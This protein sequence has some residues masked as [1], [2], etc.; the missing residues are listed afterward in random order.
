MLL[1]TLSRVEGNKTGMEM[2]QEE[3]ETSQH[4]VGKPVAQNPFWKL[5]RTRMRSIKILTTYRAVAFENLYRPTMSLY[6]AVH[7][8]ILL[9]KACLRWCSGFYTVQQS[10]FTVIFRILYGP[11]KCIYGDVQDY[12][13]SDNKYLW[14]WSWF[15]IVQLS[16]CGDVQGSI[17]NN[18]VPLGRKL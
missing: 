1:F 12:I 17:L 3:K 6:G 18:N 2:I 15:Y 13:L 14:W 8:S 5:R 9:N 11:T 4:L 7:C 10:V 16:I